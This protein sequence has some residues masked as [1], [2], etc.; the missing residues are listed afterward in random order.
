MEREIKRVKRGRHVLI[1]AGP[2]TRGHGTTGMAKLWKHHL[3]E[4][5]GA[6][7]PTK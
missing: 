1:P 2:D 3:A 6:A 4:L 7:P 5:L